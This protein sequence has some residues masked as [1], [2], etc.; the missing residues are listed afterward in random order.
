M[1]TRPSTHPAMTLELLVEAARSWTNRVAPT[2]ERNDLAGFDVPNSHGSVLAC[3]DEVAAGNEGQRNG[4]VAK[5]ADHLLSR[6]IPQLDI[7]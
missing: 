3:G 7:V 2:S 5:A 1:I 6:Q 4:L